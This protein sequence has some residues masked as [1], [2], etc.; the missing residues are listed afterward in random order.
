MN[1]FGSKSKKISKIRDSHFVEGSI[2][3]RLAF[4]I[5]SHFKTEHSSNL[6]TFAVF[7]PKMAK[8]DVTKTF[9]QKKIDGFSEILVA[10][11]KLMLGK[12][13]KF[14]R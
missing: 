4:L 7:L 8:H 10:D 12:V 14:S 9:S 1:F 6:K 5:A 11:V 3:R 13:L 2:L